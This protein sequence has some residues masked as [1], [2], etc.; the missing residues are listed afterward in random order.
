MNPPNVL[1]IV[2]NCNCFFLSLELHQGGYGTKGLFMKRNH[3]LCHVN[4]HCWL[5]EGGACGVHVK[6]RRSAHQNISTECYT[7]FNMSGNLRC[8]YQSWSCYWNKKNVEIPSK[9]L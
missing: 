3:L 2:S 9:I 1:R 6:V 7:I 8:T 5:V 4:K